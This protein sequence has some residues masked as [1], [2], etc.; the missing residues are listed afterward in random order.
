MRIAC[1]HVPQFALQTLTRID[2]SLRGVPVAVVG[3]GIDPSTYGAGAVAALTSPVVQ[4]CSRAAWALGVRVGMTATA[5]NATAPGQLRVVSGD[6]A[7]ERETVRAIADALLSVSPLVDVGGRLGPGGAHLA[8]YCEVPSKTR[9]TSFGDKLVEL[10]ATL[11][12]TARIGIADDRFTAWVAAA[13]GAIVARRADKPDGCRA[14]SGAEGAA[15][16]IDKGAGLLDETGVVSV[17]RGGSAAFLA[18]RPLSLLAITP[19]VQHMLEALGV[20]TLGEFA[21]LPAPSVA[22]RPVEADYQALA[23][24]DS[25]QSLRPYAPEAPIREDVVL[26]ATEGGLSTSAAIAHLAERISARLAG[27]GRGAARLE[28]MLSGASGEQVVPILPGVTLREERLSRGL[29]PVSDLA[30]P[31]SESR[32]ASASSGTFGSARRIVESIDE[33]ADAIG[34]AIDPEAANPWRL[35][36]TVTGEAIASDASDEVAAQRTRANDAAVDAFT[37]DA[38]ATLDLLDVV[39]SSTGGASDSGTW[40]LTPPGHPQSLRDERRDAHRRTQR[41]KA[42]ERRRTRDREFV[43]ARLFGDRK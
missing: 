22:R 12:L 8:M 32:G 35:R 33:L 29:V 25:G 37:A 2:P 42:A 36:V 9:G 1:V 16:V 15:Q 7:L 14:R 34:L 31:V 18:P 6:Q 24:G 19:E 20:R 11:G 17:P 43:Q 3:S 13:H 39:L 23:R 26:S 21:A 4:A 5:A 38:T 27:R 30:A 10:L 40:R 41:G 28:V